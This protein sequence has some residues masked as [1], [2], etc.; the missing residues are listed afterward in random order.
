MLHGASSAADGP[1]KAPA[2][3]VRAF[4]A[5]HLPPC[6]AAQSRP[7]TDR[8]RLGSCCLALV[9]ALCV[10]SST[11]IAQQRT[12]QEIEQFLPQIQGDSDTE[13]ATALSAIVPAERIGA[14]DVAQWS[15]ALHGVKSRQ[16]L[17]AL[18]DQSEFLDPT[19]AID[20]PPP[21]PDIATQRQ[22]MASV[23]RYVRDSIPWFP[24]FFATRTTI[25]FED[26]PLLPGL[27][28]SVIAR[29]LPLQVVNRA[30]TTV[31][32]S[33]GREQV[34]APFTQTRKR[35]TL[36][37]GPHHPRCLRPH[38]SNRPG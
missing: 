13:A 3:S 36:G 22:I 32:Y 7:V 8:S 25:Q 11:L 6:L 10:S 38:S 5:A 1:G 33:K 19:P 9:V 12:N 17:M 34:G 26:R 16:A 14:A 27:S 24:N 18:V 15:S 23:A 35:Q 2:Q 31:S 20:P 4:S 29:A 21:D 37:T 30:T 28:G